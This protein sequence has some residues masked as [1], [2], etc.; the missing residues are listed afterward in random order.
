MLQ[1]QLKQQLAA[2]EMESAKQTEL[3]M[4]KLQQQKEEAKKKYD[5]TDRQLYIDMMKEQKALPFWLLLQV[6][7]QSCLFLWDLVYGSWQLQLSPV[8]L[9]K[10]M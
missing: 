2:N 1:E 7:L 10:K 4:L 9:Q 5:S 6:P 3:A 8:L